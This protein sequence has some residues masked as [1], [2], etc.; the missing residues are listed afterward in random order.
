MKI[1]DCFYFFD[2]LDLLEIR[3]NILNDV[4][5]YFVISEADETF[6][7]KK[8]CLLF[9]ENYDRYK[10]WHHKIIYVNP[11]NFEAN[12][13][14]LKKAYESKNTGN[15][16]DVW[17]REFYQKESID[18]ALSS[19]QE[20]DLIFISD[21]DEIWNPNINLKNVKDLVYRPVQEC[22]P[23]YLNLKSN[24]S[25]DCWTGTRFSKYK[26][27]KQ[28]GPNHFRTEREVQ[29]I[30]INDGGWHFTWLNKKPNKFGDNHPDNNIRL[31][32]INSSNLEINDV[33]LPEYLVNNK[34]KWITYFL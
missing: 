8:K 27:Y 14:L 26:T 31:Q 29:G 25:I 18:F 23:F 20:D 24:L 19:C 30:K 21:L 4:V 3:L 15:K 28:Y 10:K 11:P 9:K 12:T 1:Y 16:E 22:R 34:S 13:F 2:E 32:Y 17:I 33:G 7:G 6:T 5:D